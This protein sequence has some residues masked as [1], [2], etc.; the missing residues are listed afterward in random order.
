MGMF[1]KLKVGDMVINSID[2]EMTPDLTF[3][4]FES[5]GGRERVRN[6]N[7]LIYYFFVDN[8]GDEPKLCLMERGVKHARVIAEI[9]APAKMVSDCVESQGSVSFFE[10]SFAIDDAIQEW[11][12]DNVLDDGDASLVRAVREQPRVEDMGRRLPVWDGTDSAA[13]RI[14]LPSVQA[15]MSDEQVAEA[16]KRWNFFDSKINPQG[17]FQTHLHDSGL[18]TLVDQRSGLM[19]QRGG[20]DIGSLRMM[21]R[22]IEELNKDGFAGYHDWRLPALEEAMSLLE[23][24]INEKGIHLNSNFSREQPFIFVAAQRTPGGYWFVDYKQGSAFWSSG[25]IPGGFGRLCRTLTS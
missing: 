16:I 13:E 7:E 5:W 9:K 6:N 18:Q 12:I 17:S 10:R 23:P 21:N 4:T 15:V 14:S 1:H 19:W 20:I 8:W 2:W 3:G 24:V 25:T 11:L 22:A